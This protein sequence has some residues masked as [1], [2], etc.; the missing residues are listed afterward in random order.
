MKILIYNSGGGIGDS[1][2]LFDILNSIKKKFTSSEI[3]YLTAHDNYFDNKLKDFRI[4]L[5]NL[6]TDVK[7][8]GFRLHHFFSI[9]KIIKE[10]SIDEFDL[11]IDL[12]SK[13]RNTL[14]L[15]KF[16]H[17]FFYSST[18]NFK[19]CNIE[20]NYISSKYD[21][22]NIISNLEKMLDEEISFSKYDINSIDN[23][24]FEEAKKLLPD[25]NY[26]GFSITQGNEYR[27]KSWSIE[28]FINLSNELY[29]KNKK[30]VYFIEKGNS[31]LINKVK[32]EVKGVLFPE[33]NSSLSG[34]PLVTALSTR[35][36]KAISID[37]GIMHMI[38]LANI[39]MI[40]LFGPTNSK[41]FAPKINDIKILDS[42]EMY[43]SKDILKITEK[44]VLDL[45]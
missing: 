9:N 41:K 6:K 1:I 19:F 36:E 11:I 12:Q 28:N 4:S 40:V 8:F 38:G 37:N 43:G 2:Q 26:I 15:K 44:D 20:K 29:K 31:E 27:K 24:Y 33:H 42:K 18:F 30:S 23:K 5:K 17:K 25:N 32:N 21:Q 7:Y 13:L 22:K 39:P 35:L 34:P 3:Y 16:P 45:I 14:I 10:N